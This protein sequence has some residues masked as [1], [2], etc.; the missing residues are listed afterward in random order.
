MGMLIIRSRMANRILIDT[1]FWY[2]FF[3]KKDCH[4]DEAL[5]IADRYFDNPA[6]EILVPFPTMYELLRT[7]FIK[8]KPA[9]VEIKQLF[10]SGRITKIYDDRYRELALDL[11]LSEEKRNISLVDN[12]IRL[13]LDDKYVS[14]KGMVT[15]N[16]GDFHDVCLKNNIEILY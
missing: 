4:R 9:L 14:A 16:V 13:M 7:K 11:T 2:A 10:L 5:D 12:I 1:G 15:F 6:Y 3:D 8:N